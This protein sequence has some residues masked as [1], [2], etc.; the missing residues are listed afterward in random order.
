MSRYRVSSSHAEDIASGAVFA[1]GETAVG[2]NPDN[3]H[4]KEL[5]DR[6]V[7]VEITRPSKPKAKKEDDAK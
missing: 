4:D 1:P 6:G 2:V 3:P 7:L 5:I